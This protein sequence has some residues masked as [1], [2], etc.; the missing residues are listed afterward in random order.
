MLRFLR[1]DPAAAH[2]PQI[3][4]ALARMPMSNTGI[5]E[6]ESGAQVVCRQ[7][8]CVVLV[9]GVQQGGVAV[10]ED[11]EADLRKPLPLLVSFC[12][13]LFGERQRLRRFHAFSCARDIIGR[14]A[15]ISGILPWSGVM[16]PDGR[17]VSAES[18]F[19]NVAS[20]F[21]MQ[22]VQLELRAASLA[23]SKSLKGSTPASVRSCSMS[24]RRLA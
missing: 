6:R 13:L 9:D 11:A 12:H 23:C 19:D 16:E 24:T 8:R 10:V 2:P 3:P 15:G 7:W 4:G 22:P 18:C 17:P 20:R 5:P 21:Q 14:T 1:L